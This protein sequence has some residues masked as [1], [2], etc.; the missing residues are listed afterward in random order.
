MAALAQH[1]QAEELDIAGRIVT[2]QAQPLNL[3]FAAAQ[4]RAAAEVTH[5]HDRLRTEI[6]L[7]AFV[8]CN[9]DISA[10]LSPGQRVPQAAPSVFHA[11]LLPTVVMECATKQVHR[12]R[13]ACAAAV[14]DKG[15]DQLFICKLTY[16]W[17]MPLGRLCATPSNAWC[18]AAASSCMHARRSSP[19]F[20][21]A[22][23]SRTAAASQA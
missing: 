18:C 11:Q 6:E 9:L 13:A 22:L 20:V 16:Y 14:A 7:Q 17:T 4:A 23:I 19:V 12:G 8:G 10:Y 21:A 3:T 5:W 1:V 15:L 2:F